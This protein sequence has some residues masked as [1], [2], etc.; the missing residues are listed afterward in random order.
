MASVIQGVMQSGL[1]MLLLFPVLL[2]PMYD[3]VN[4][5]LL[6]DPGLFVGAY[7]MDHSSAQPRVLLLSGT[8]SDLSGGAGPAVRRHNS[9][10]TGS[11]RSHTRA[12]WIHEGYIYPFG[13]G[14]CIA[15][16]SS[17]ATVYM[18]TWL[19][20]TC[21]QGAAGPGPSH[22]PVSFARTLLDPSSWILSPG[23]L[24]AAG[25]TARGML[26]VE[27][28]QAQSWAGPSRYCT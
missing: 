1:E 13:T 21:T 25:E 17:A 4:V 22:G 14:P 10:D 23:K 18:W 27:P 8:L 16:A 9:L 2:V 28:H 20:I 6:R 15:L 5:A 12:W 7:M 19:Q 11:H 3:Y 26:G 24:S